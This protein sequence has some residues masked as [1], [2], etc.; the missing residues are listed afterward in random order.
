MD[1]KYLS[2][3]KRVIYEGRQILKVFRDILIT[4]LR[5]KTSLVNNPPLSMG[6]LR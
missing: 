3:L 4:A 2:E 5:P 6:V 1:R